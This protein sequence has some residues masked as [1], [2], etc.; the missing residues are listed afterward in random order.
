MAI[1]VLA[2][3]KGFKNL[4]VAD[5]AHD[6]EIARLIPVVQ[7]FMENYCRRVFEQNTT[8]TEYHSG[9][10]GQ[11]VLM[12]NQPPIASIASIHDD[13]LRVYGASALVAASKYLVRDA[14]AGIVQ[15]DGWSL[16]EGLNN[17][18][19]VYSGG[20]PP[21]DT[22][23]KALEQAAIELIW[24]ARDKGDQALLG[25]SSKSV[26]DGSYTVLRNDWPAGV[27]TILDLYRLDVL[28]KPS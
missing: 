27:Q 16:Q 9:K 10:A 4:G 1:T 24:L 23:L 13:P 8:V 11:A 7:D 12:L 14:E 21:A 2:N 6:A 15:F 5:T 20:F 22:E 28:G 17:V 26:A 19:V 25:L 18:K 3:V